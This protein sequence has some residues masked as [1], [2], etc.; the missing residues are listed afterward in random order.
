MFILDTDPGL[1]D[2]IALLLMNHFISNEPCAIVASYGNASLE[3]TR[4]N[5]AGLK[6]SFD[7]ACP[8]FIG[9]AG[10]LSGEKPYFDCYHGEDA[11][12][13][14]SKLLDT[15]NETAQPLNDLESYVGDDPVVHYCCIGPM[16]T[17]AQLILSN[18]PI[19]SKIRC[20]LAMGGGIERFNC[21]NKSEFNFHSD[22]NAV[23]VVFESGIPLV[24]AP[25]D[26]GMEFPLTVAEV[27]RVTKACP[28]KIVG[29]LVSE[30][31]TSARA[32]NREH[33]DIHDGFPVLYHAKKNA[34]LAE[35]MR[36]SVDSFGAIRE[37]DSGREVLVLRSP[38]K[39]SL[40]SDAII[41]ACPR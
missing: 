19:V 20:I 7:I 15:K 22:P 3:V 32:H 28:H 9:A 12:R 39:E 26:L 1:D 17:L 10:P 33:A 5:L 25:F 37:E 38:V 34:F 6:K 18:S 8:T 11:L 35:T 41:E 27:E 4:K 36:L 14:I 13:G 31:L 30:S 16:T 21:P 23:R 24:I 2:G 29:K 40:L